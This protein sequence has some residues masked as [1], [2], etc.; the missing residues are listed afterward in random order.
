MTLFLIMSISCIII[1]A[2]VCSNINVVLG[3]KLEVDQYSEAKRIF[4]LLALN[5]ALTFPKSIFVCNTTAHEKFVF[6]KSLV[7]SVD[8]LTPIL[9]IVICCFFEERFCFNFSHNSSHTFR[10]HNQYSL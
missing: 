2:I 3:D 9:Q 10:F 6:Q 1:G 8:V 7:L 5:M 4:F